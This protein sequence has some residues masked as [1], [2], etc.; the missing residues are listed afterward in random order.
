MKNFKQFTITTIPKNFEII[1]GLLWQLDLNGI[2]ETENEL[3]IFIDETKNISLKEIKEILEEAKKNNLIAVSQ[4]LQK[5]KAELE[6]EKKELQIQQENK[7]ML[8]SQLE[9]QQDKLEQMLDEMEE[10]SQEISKKIKQILAQQKTKRK[11]VGGKLAWPLEAEYPITSYFGMRFHPI[12]KKT[13]MHTGIDIGAPYGSNILAAA[14]GEVITAEWVPAY[15]LTVI[16]DNGSGIVT[17]YAHMSK[18]LVHKGQ[19]VKRNNV[20]GRVGS[21]GYSTGPHL[22]FEVRINGDVVN[23]LSYLK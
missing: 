21:T 17:L 14:D 11:Y 3:I 2:N 6:S 16:I 12:L 20:I 15:G 10:I 23:P 8:L 1:S 18:I 4:L 9:S 5:E 13:K 19:V 22:H 7:K